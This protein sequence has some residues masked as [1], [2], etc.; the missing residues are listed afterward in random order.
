LQHADHDDKRSAAGGAGA[1]YML[2]FITG[3]IQN[4]QQSRYSW[5]PALSYFYRSW[6]AG[7]FCT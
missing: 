6:Y 1:R 2:T 5:Q 4:E 3:D 7:R